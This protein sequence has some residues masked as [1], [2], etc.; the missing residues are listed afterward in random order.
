M[1]SLQSELLD[2]CN[3]V[4]HERLARVTSKVELWYGLLPSAAGLARS[5]AYR[6]RCNWPRTMLQGLLTSR[7]HYPID[8][9]LTD[10]AFIVTI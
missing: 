10:S 4:S 3:R 2:A 1:F 7:E 9:S 5:N 8:A 6:N